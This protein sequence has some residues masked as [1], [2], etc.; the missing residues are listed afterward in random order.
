MAQFATNLL[1]KL[2]TRQVGFGGCIVGDQ[3]SFKFGVGESGSQSWRKYLQ[4]VV[5]F[6]VGLA[7]LSWAHKSPL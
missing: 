5:E 1:P 3:P 6:S 7:H 4:T 2:L